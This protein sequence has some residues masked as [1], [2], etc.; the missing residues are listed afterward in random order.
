MPD[1]TLHKSEYY[2]YSDCGIF[3][4]YLHGNEVFGTQMLFLSQFILTEYASYINHVEVVRAKNA[5]YNELL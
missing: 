2:A 3:G 4:N 5:I 1:I